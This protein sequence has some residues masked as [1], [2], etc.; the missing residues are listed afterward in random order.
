MMEDGQKALEEAVKN[1]SQK[2]KRSSAG[3]K[4]PNKKLK[5]DKPE[6]K[7]DSK[8]QIKGQSKLQ[9]K[10]ITTK[11]NGTPRK[12]STS[13]DDTPL[14]NL[15]KKAKKESSSGS[16]DS[17]TPLAVIAK[18]PKKPATPKKTPKKK[19][20]EVVEIDSD[21]SDVALSKII[22]S[23]QKVKTPAGLKSPSSGKRGRGR[24]AG[25]VNKTPEQ[26]VRHKLT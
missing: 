16:E 5:L 13:S 18:S 21:D 8:G 4:P 2:R 25:S 10:T 1:M 19:K 14:V 23:P 12:D 20:K 6:K 26:R 7:R 11:V 17:D 24:P 22:K 3:G 15:K 9:F